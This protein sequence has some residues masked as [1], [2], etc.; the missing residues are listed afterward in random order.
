[1]FYD[2]SPADDYMGDVYNDDPHF[3]VPEG[4]E[5]F[6]A[7]VSCRDSTCPQG[8]ESREVEVYHPGDEFYCSSCGRRMW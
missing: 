5:R 8:E 7:N 2:T 4:F 6:T 3:S 1:M